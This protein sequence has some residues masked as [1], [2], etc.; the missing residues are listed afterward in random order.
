MHR[1]F[2]IL[3][4]KSKNNEVPHF[5]IFYSLLYSDVIFRA[6]FSNAIN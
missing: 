2:S 1:E 5:V 3:L 6:L 4:V